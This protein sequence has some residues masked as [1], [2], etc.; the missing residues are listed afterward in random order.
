[1]KVVILCGGKG[2]RLAEETNLNPKP[3]VKIGDKPIIWHIL[4]FFNHYGHNEFILATGY[5]NEVINDFFYNNK[6]FPNVKTIFTGAE[7]MT[8][9]RILRLKSILD[10]EEEFFMTYGDGVTNLNLNEL[11]KFHKSHNKIATVTA[12]HPPVRF[13]EV[14]INKNQVTNFAE[15]K[16]AKSSWISGGFFILNKKIFNYI[17]NDET[18]FEEYPL[19]KITSE[20]Q[21]M[22]YK[23]EGFWQCMD[24]LREK[25][26]LDDL[27]YKGVAPWKV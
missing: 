15:K 16:Q 2:T 22:A 17:K 23:H 24:T 6:D 7:T 8:G 3:M 25:K 12:V 14:E 18:V 27:W 21:L 5:K 19:E 1:M 26:L 10:K 4:K 11:L 13:G 9:G 20:G